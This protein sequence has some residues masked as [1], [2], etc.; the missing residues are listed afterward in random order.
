MSKTDEILSPAVEANTEGADGSASEPER[1]LGIRDRYLDTE[2]WFRMEADIGRKVNAGTLCLDIHYLLA[3]L[4]GKEQLLDH[5][6]KVV[7][8]LSEWRRMAQGRLDAAS[9]QI[10]QILSDSITDSAEIE[11]LNAEVKQHKSNESKRF[12]R[13]REVIERVDGRA[14]AADGPVPPTEQEVTGEEMR[15]IYRLA[16]GKPVE[17][18]A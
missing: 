8:G 5:G 18:Q 7:T 17:A 4:R 12:S 1:I 15:E 11:R 9:E 2:E 14:L 6:A 10:S 16:G 3:L 13:I